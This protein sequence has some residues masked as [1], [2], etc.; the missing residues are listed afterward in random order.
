MRRKRDYIIIY[1]I[2]TA[3]LLISSG[4]ICL[5]RKKRFAAKKT[6][7]III[8]IDSL[9]PDHLGCYGYD[10][11]T[12]PAIDK[13]SRESTRFTQAISA[14]GWT[15]ESVPSIL[16]GTYSFIHKFDF[17]GSNS[18]DPSIKTL[19]QELSVKNYQTAIWSNHPAIK[20]M[21]IKNTF[22]EANAESLLEGCKP[23]L[24]DSMLTSKIQTWLY[25]KKDSPFFLY[26]HYWGCHMPY[27]PPFPYNRIYM[28][29]KYR[30]K[31]K[32]V[33]I[34]SSDTEEEK[35][36]G[37]GVIPYVAVENNI[38][39]PNYY[40]TQYD[41]TVSYIDKQIERLIDTLKK[42]GLDKNTLI[43]LSS[44]HGEMLGEHDMYFMHG[45]G[46]E[47]NIR[48]PLIICYPEFFPKGKV[49]SRQISLIDIAPTILEIAGLTK[50]S[51][52]QGE[53]LLSLVKPFRSYQKEY[54]F[55]SQR[56]D[57]TLRTKKWKLIYDSRVHSSQLFDIQKDS[58]ELHNV[59]NDQPR[60]VEDYKNRL[61]S[62]TKNYIGYKNLDKEE[63]KTGTSLNFIMISVDSLRPDHL[64]GYGYKRNTSP[65]IDRLVK[66]GV[67]FTQ[68]IA[69]GGCAF[70]SVNKN[71]YGLAYSIDQHFATLVLELGRKH[72]QT[73]LWSDHPGV[74]HSEIKNSFEEVNMG[75]LFDD[76]ALTNK[77]KI[78]LQDRARAPFFLYIHYWGNHAPYKPPNP[79]KFMFISDSYNNNQQSVPISIGYIGETTNYTKR[80]ISFALALN[81]ITD[82]NYYIAQ[83]D[84]AVF[85]IDAQ[86]GKLTNSLKDLGLDKNTVVIL[87]ADHGEML[88]EHDMYFYHSGGYEE[89]IKVPLIISFPRLFPQGKV[90][91]R[92]VS[93][94]DIVPTIFEIADLDKPA[95]LRGESLMALFKNSREYHSDYAFFSQDEYLVLRTESWKTIYNA[96]EDSWELFNLLKDPRELH[97]VSKDEPAVVRN[98]QNRMNQFV[99]STQD[100]K[101][102]GDVKNKALFLEEMRKM[103]YW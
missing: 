71:D 25:K 55:S 3:I 90:V 4:I 16:T 102:P 29:D 43:I 15:F 98:M 60:I 12:S 65:Y 42:A 64:G 39:D 27:R 83:Y 51:Y 103:G 70:E 93:L 36:N 47:E 44:D 20:Y 35:T 96:K 46:Q 77:I 8:T 87:T 100:I 34:S 9:R 7:F 5:Q 11:N 21:D 86:V 48:V 49:I 19:S 59:V 10:R 84:G 82:P 99:E 94:L 17:G 31:S 2:I 69:S 68:A 85:N 37:V 54:V 89:N 76:S 45:R 80:K 97:D 92:Q 41:G 79:Y 62:W 26:I 73:V 91:S 75:I 58:H 78:Y 57:L 66:E 13:L 18:I 40:I 33:A 61:I 50:P 63:N 56:E 38:I 95:F 101:H 72:Y 53:S 24:T 28:Y 74:K 30:K 88:G 1:T 14:G 6:N 52:M 23:A 22:Q 81:N 67:R 32:P